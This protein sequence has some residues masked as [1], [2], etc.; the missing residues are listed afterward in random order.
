MATIGAEVGQ[1][2]RSAIKA[3]L[4]ELNC[5]VDDELPDYVMVM[6]ANKRTKSQMKDDLQLFLSNKTATFVDWLHIVLKKLKEVTV[7][8]PDVYKK[9]P[10]RKSDE[11]PNVNVKKEKKEKKSGK[12]ETKTEPEQSTESVFKSLTDDLP[13][14]ANR[15]SEQRK[16]IIMKENKSNN[17]RK[18]MQD[19]FDIPLLSE[20]NMSTEEELEDLENK[21][22]SVKSR[23][24]LLVES[25]EEEDCIKLKP[26]PDELLPTENE[27]KGE[28]KV[29]STTTAAP[30]PP[31]RTE[32]S[33]ITFNEEHETRRKSILDRLGKRRSGD[34]EEAASSKRNRIDLSDFRKEDSSKTRSD[35]REK[36]FRRDDKSKEG[37]LSR[38]GVMSKVSVP[39]KAPEEPEEPFKNRE[40]PSV[41]KIKPRVIPPDAPQANKN[42]LLKAVAEAQKS[43]AQAPKPDALYT[44]KYKEK[45]KD[46]PSSGKKLPEVEKNKIKKFLAVS[47]DDSKR[48]ETEEY[49]PTPIKRVQEST[50][51]YIPTSKTND[52]DD[53][54]VEN[55]KVKQQFIV[56]LDGIE[57]TKYKDLANEEPKPSVKSRLDKKKSPS[58]I[59]FDKVENTIK[60]KPNIPDKLP[61]IHAS[62]AVK[63]K[64]RCKYWPSCRQGDKCEFVH[65]TT[66]CEKFPHCKFGDKCLFLHPTCKFGSSCTRRGCV[67]SHAAKGTGPSPVKLAGPVQT[68]KFFPNCTNVNCAFYHPKPCKFGKYCKNQADCTFSHTFVPNK[69]SLTWRSK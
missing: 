5:Y 8:N 4:L 9:P 26:E 67:Y 18:V 55:G 38:V 2:M 14:S 30:Q 51:K 54:S 48:D 6:V 25:D 32:H 1:K 22:K 16:I 29:E 15:L 40:V 19:N 46:E 57:R 64:E 24:G 53:S 35:R 28:S 69:S 33:R 52:S 66:T 63:N 11:L 58:P 56:T 65:P 7:T 62:P 42:L 59:I 41:V 31:K 12:K 34:N 61:L 45:R 20:V 37:V 3:K 50:T 27:N 49:I 21:I 47:D 44:K 13:I 23:L 36:R 39:V 10:K 17:S 60:G 68:C 43:I